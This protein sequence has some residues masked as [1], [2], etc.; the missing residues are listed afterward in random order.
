M[1]RDP[2]LVHVTVVPL[3][4]FKYFH[5]LFNPLEL[6]LYRF[7]TEAFEQR[8]ASDVV[9]AFREPWLVL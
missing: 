4:P 1:E 7:K 5:T 8:D 3:S 2:I 6:L 9:E